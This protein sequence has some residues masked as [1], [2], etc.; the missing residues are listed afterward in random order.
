MDKSKS[1]LN[2]GLSLAELMVALAIL[3]VVI[4]MTLSFFNEMLTGTFEQEQKN[5]LNRS[6]RA[7]MADFSAQSRQAD[8]I[9]LYKSFAPNDHKNTDD[10]LF[11]GKTGNFLLLV[12]QGEPT[13]Q[14]GLSNKRPIKKLIGYYLSSKET[15]KPGPFKRFLI[16]YPKGTY[17]SPEDLIPKS[18]P[19][20][21]KILVH[22]ARGLANDQAFYNL[23]NRNVIIDMSLSSGN[24]TKQYSHNFYFTLSPRE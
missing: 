16:E 3:G 1:S 17:N 24:E 9:L 12:I 7:L 13:N 15:N 10:R 20:N 5:E 21:T 22:Q 19:Q 4:A 6:I 18:E 14:Q 8:Y 2:R 23:N 11:E